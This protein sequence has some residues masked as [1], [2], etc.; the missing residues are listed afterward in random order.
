MSYLKKYE[1]TEE[2]ATFNAGSDEEVTLTRIR[3]LQDIPRH[4]V[5]AGDLG[6]FI[7]VE[8]CL[9]HFGDAWVAKNALVQET[10]TVSGDALVTDE[11]VLN[12]SCYLHGTIT[13]SGEVQLFGVNLTGNNIQVEDK[14]VMVG[15]RL[16][17]NNIHIKDEAV[18]YQLRSTQQVFDLTICDEAH[19]SSRSDSDYTEITGDFITISGKAKLEDVS[20]IHGSHIYFEEKCEVTGAFFKG[21]NIRI[22][23]IACL[24]GNVNYGSQVVVGDAVLIKAVGDFFLEDIQLTGDGIYYAEH[25]QQTA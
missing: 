19:I 6:G 9:S 22:H 2:K 1:W 15:C 13:I 17:G 7:E 4:G 18:I 16:K 11:A 23:G 10:S 20:G 8:S 14:V 3:A 12:L 21:K 25:L 5:K 24:T